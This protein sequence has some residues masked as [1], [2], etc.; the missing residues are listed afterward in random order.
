M[1][2]MKKL[3]ELLTLACTGSLLGSEL[4]GYQMASGDL[5]Q[6]ALT[7]AECARQLARQ[8]YPSLA[9][10]AFTAGLIHDCG[11]LI[12]DKYMLERQRYFED[13]MNHGQ[14]P[15][16]TAEQQVFGFDHAE[17]AAEVC[18]K[19]QIPKN[20]AVAIKNH[21]NTGAVSLNE[22]A[23]VVHAADA[24]ALTSG[25]GAGIDS[26]MYD[27]DEKTVQVFDLTQN[28]L[29]MYMLQI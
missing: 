3:N 7:T 4:K 1:L 28:N 22:L 26:M 19:W 5:W 6:H 2:G 23:R 25:I 17:I 24:I 29:E 16:Q 20:I 9:D 10:A 13:F 11:K 12:L 8:M 15:F 27:I 21:H 14:R 18:E